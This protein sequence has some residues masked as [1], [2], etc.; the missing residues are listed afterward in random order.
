M[1]TFDEVVVG[2]GPTVAMVACQ[3]PD[4][5]LVGLKGCVP[6]LLQLDKNLIGGQGAPVAAVNIQ[7][8]ELGKKEKQRDQ[9]ANCYLLQLNGK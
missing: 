8:K 1:L 7:L 9:V 4:G 2:F 3:N 6:N 5:L